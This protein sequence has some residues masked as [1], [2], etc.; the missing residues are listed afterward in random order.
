MQLR[1]GSVLMAVLML[2]L[3]V[4][5][6][7]GVHPC[8]NHIVTASGNIPLLFCA[9]VVSGVRVT[10]VVMCKMFGVGCFC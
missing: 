9:T 4:L 2:M 10:Q 8:A 5:W 3:I 7:T 6:F 1:T